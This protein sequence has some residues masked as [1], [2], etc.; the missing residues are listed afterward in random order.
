[1]ILKLPIG[2]EIIK[3]MVSRRGRECFFFSE[4]NMAI[5]SMV[6]LM[7]VAGLALL[8]ALGFAAIEGDYTSTYEGVQ[9]VRI[10]KNGEVYQVR[11]DLSDGTHWVGV[12]LLNAK[13]DM[14]T[15]ASVVSK[16]KDEE[17]EN[18]SLHVSVFKVATKGD[19]VTKL[20]SECARYGDKKTHQETL[21]PKKK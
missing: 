10:T 21:T 19:K 8:P 6:F 17:Y 18:G 15:V 5:R 16:G 13:G 12:G 20:V 14:F 1:V 4:V 7:A 9:K 11:W 3:V 2:W